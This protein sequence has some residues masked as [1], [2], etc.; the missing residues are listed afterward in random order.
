MGRQLDFRCRVG[1]DFNAES[2]GFR[3]R[4]AD[5]RQKADILRGMLLAAASAREPE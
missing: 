2:L 5:S 4:A 3:R 1:C